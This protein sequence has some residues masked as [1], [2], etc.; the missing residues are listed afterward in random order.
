ME[1]K[2]KSLMDQILVNLFSNSLK[3]NDKDLTEI[4]LSVSKNASHYLFVVSDNG[5]GIIKS[6]QDS[7]F[8]LFQVGSVKDRYGNR[9]NGIG[10]ASVK[11]V[12]ERL[13]GEIHLESEEGDGAHFYFSI[14]K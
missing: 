8:N 14:A 10:L 6:K 13:G 3:Y 4:E 11:K 9:G 12:I 1:V 5:P 2:K 7:I